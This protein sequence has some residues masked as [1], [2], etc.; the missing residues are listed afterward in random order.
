RPI[1]HYHAAIK[2]RGSVSKV[3][4]VTPMA[5]IYIV[6]FPPIS[7]FETPPI[8]KCAYPG[9]TRGRVH[10]GCERDPGRGSTRRGT[11]ACAPRAVRHCRGTPTTPVHHR[12]PGSWLSSM[13]EAWGPGPGFV[14]A[15]P[16][17]V[18]CH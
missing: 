7:T 8:L 13:H 5:L 14:G 4:M 10:A 6:L 16:R 3:E 11:S 1:F 17:S 15:A 12:F 18:A 9:R 2:D